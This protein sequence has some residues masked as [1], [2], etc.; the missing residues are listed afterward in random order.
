[1][2]IEVPPKASRGCPRN[3]FWALRGL[4]RFGS[5]LAFSSGS[6]GLEASGFSML[7]VS[8]FLGLEVGGSSLELQ[9]L[10]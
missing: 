10:T 7:I 9:F 8:A 6:G 3:N 1:M 2:F 5:I 4:Y